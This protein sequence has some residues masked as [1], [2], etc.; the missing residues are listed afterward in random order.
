MLEDAVE[1]PFGF[2]FQQALCQAIAH[3]V[4][5]LAH[6]SEGSFDAKAGFGAKVLDES[7]HFTG[8]CTLV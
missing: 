1:E 7:F 8:I 5:I 3:S 6:A 2:A 4:V